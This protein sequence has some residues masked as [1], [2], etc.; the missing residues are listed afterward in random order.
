MTILPASAF[1]SA[2]DDSPGYSN[3]PSA[4]GR[5]DHPAHQ[6]RRL[7]CAVACQGSREAEDLHAKVHLHG[8]PAIE[9]RK[10]RIEAGNT[11]EK[12]V[13]QYLEFKRINYG[14]VASLKSSGI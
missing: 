4:P 2:M 7:S 8:D 1:D 14:P 9:R 12:L 5:P 13:Q 10:T 3:M 6:D 11:F